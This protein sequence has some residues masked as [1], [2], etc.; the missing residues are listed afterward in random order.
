[1][2]RAAVVV[3]ALALAVASP[4]FAQEGEPKGIGPDVPLHIEDLLCPLSPR[5]LEGC[6]TQGFHARHRGI[7]ISLWGGT[8]ISAT[9]A[10]TVACGGWVGGHFGNLVIIRS[11]GD[12]PEWESWYGHLDQVLVRQGQEVERGQLIALSG[13]TGEKTTGAHLHYE[14]HHFGVPA[15]PLGLPEEEEGLTVGTSSETESPPGIPR[16]EEMPLTPT[17]PA[18][19][20]TK[21]DRGHD[22]LAATG[23]TIATVTGSAA[24]VVLLAGLAFNALTSL[25]Q[26][27]AVRSLERTYRRQKAQELKLAMNQTLTS[28]QEQVRAR[29]ATDPDAWRGVVRQLLTD[30]GVDGDATLANV[31]DISTTPCPHFTVSGA[32][33]QPCYLFTTDPGSLHSSRTVRRHDQTVLLDMTLSPFARVEAQ[34]LWD[35]LAGERLRGKQSALPRDAAW[36]LVIRRRTKPVPRAK[37]KRWSWSWRSKRGR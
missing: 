12:P 30:A 32:N 6:I 9:H 1:M 3:L 26:A 14:I 27:M 5:G 28:H 8:P 7:D 19:L 37:K 18:Y 16:E 24:V 21:E 33:G 35:H 22:E 36:W 2:S 20:N 4:A 25:T 15:D 34:A 23:P 11:E 13:N 17:P 10:G 29:L 31:P